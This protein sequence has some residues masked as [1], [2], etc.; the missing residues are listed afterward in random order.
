M[1][2]VRVKVH[3][4]SIDVNGDGVGIIYRQGEVFDCPAD[5]A[6]RLGNSVQILDI[7][8]IVPEP[9]PNPPDIKEPVVATPK[10]ITPRHRR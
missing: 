10:K 2:M 8:A 5:R 9:E 3:N 6:T 7:P 1:V 4:L